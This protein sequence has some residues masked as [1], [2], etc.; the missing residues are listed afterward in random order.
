[1]GD[2]PHKLGLCSFTSL[3]H[4]LPQLARCTHTSFGQIVATLPQLTWNLKSYR[5]KTPAV[6]RGPF[7]T[8]ISVW[9]SARATAVVAADCFMPA[10]CTQIGPQ[11]EI[12]NAECHE[13]IQLTRYPLTLLDPALQAGLCQKQSTGQADDIPG[14][15]QEELRPTVETNKRERVIWIYE[16]VSTFLTNSEEMDP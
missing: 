10:H 4:A 5:L 13:Q 1:M 16:P 8:S 11:V 9:R 12:R 3:K 15:V 14:P 6:Y 7:P 2:S